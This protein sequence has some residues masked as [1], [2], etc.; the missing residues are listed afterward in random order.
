VPKTKS[1]KSLKRP[2]PTTIEELL[3]ITNQE[4]IVAQEEE[5][6]SKQTDAKMVDE[7]MIEVSDS[8]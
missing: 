4:S 8:A 1:G 5:S 3:Q 2:P 7:S 6:A